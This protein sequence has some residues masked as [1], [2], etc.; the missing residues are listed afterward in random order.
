MSYAPAD[1]TLVTSG[2]TLITPGRL[3]TL[4]LASAALTAPV[5]L[6]LLWL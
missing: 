5:S 3:P 6:F 4:M 1:P 2:A